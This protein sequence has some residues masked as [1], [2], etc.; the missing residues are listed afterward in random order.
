MEPLN[1]ARAGAAAL[2]LLVPGA[3]CRNDGGLQVTALTPPAADPAMQSS[4]PGLAVAPER[5][6]L[7]ASWAEGD[8]RTWTLY[9]A[10]SADGGAGWTRPVKVAGGPE[11]PGEVHPHGESSP[12]LVAASGDRLALVWPNS[13]PVEGRKWP[14]AMLRFARS[15]DGGH[16]WSPPRTINDDTTGALVSHQ[17]HGAAWVGDTGL[18]VAWLDE[19]HAHAPIASGSDGHAAHASEPDATIY[20]ATSRDF[21]DTWGANRVAWSAACPCCRVTLARDPEGRAVAAWR[22]HF[23]GNVRDVVTA[24]VTDGPSPEPGRV[25][26]DDWS[27]PG[28][29]HRGP[30]IAVGED[31]AR[32]VVWYN[33]RE[34]E[35]GVYYARATDGAAAERRV[36]LVT[37]RKVSTAHAAVAA[38]ADGGALA[39]W[40]ITA[41]GERRISIARLSPAG[42]IVGATTIAD[43]RDGKY[44]QLAVLGDSTALLA[45]TGTVGEG[46]RMRLARIVWR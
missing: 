38:L 11:A 34:G 20:L 39:A 22:K 25:H 6:D 37:G 9:V 44:P 41:D 16:T 45:W 8:G 36:G 12:R 15:T 2:L 26:T 40:D 27:Y 18:T 24:M 23:P 4:D 30:A 28:C 46:A 43:S 29:P 19:R 5:G 33:G 13:I 17:F 14:A 3:A 35:A 21:G 7:V 10:R 42:A 32:H 31:G 1:R